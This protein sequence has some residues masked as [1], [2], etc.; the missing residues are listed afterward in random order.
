MGA[1]TLTAEWSLSCSGVGV[2]VEESHWGQW[3]NAR[4]VKGEL[5]GNKRRGERN[6]LISA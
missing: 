4:K 3:R 5:N 6:E 1:D 2:G